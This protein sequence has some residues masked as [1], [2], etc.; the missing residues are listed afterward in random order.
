MSSKNFTLSFYISIADIEIS[1]RYDYVQASVSCKSTGSTNT[2]TFSDATESTTAWVD[3]ADKELTYLNR[4]TINLDANRVLTGFKLD[5]DKS[6]M[7][8][9]YWTAVL[10]VDGVTVALENLLTTT[11]NWAQ[12]NKKETCYLA[13]AHDVKIPNGRVMTGFHVASNASKQV[14]Y[15]S[16]SKTFP[17]NKLIVQDDGNVVLYDWK[18]SPLWQSDTISLAASLSQSTPDSL[19]MGISMAQEQYIQSLSGVYFARVQA[20]GNFAIFSSSTFAASSIVGESKSKDKGVAPYR[21]NLQ[22]DGNLVIIDSKNATTWSSGTSGLGTFPHRLVMQNDGNMVIYDALNQATWA[23]NT[24]CFTLDFLKEGLNLKQGSYIASPNRNFYLVMQVDGNLVMYS[25]SSFSSDRVVWQTNTNG[26]GTAPYRAALQKDGNLVVYDSLNKALW[27]A[28]AEGRGSGS[29]YRLQVQDTGCLS[30]FDGKGSSTWSSYTSATVRAISD[31]LANLDKLVQ[32][33]YLQSMNGTFYLRMQSDGNLVVYCNN[34]WATNHIVW[35]SNTKARGVAPYRSVMQSDGNL[36]VYDSANTPIWASGS[37]GKG[38]APYRLSMQ[39]DGNL[40]IYDASQ[41]AT[42][43]T[44]TDCYVL[45]SIN[46]DVS[47]THGNYMCSPNGLYYL[48]MRKEGNLAL[49]KSG[50][51]NNDNITW[52]TSTGGKGTGPYRMTMQ[53]DGNLVVY[54]SASTPL[55][56]SNTTGKGTAPYKLSVKD[57]GNVVIND[58]KGKSIWTTCTTSTSTRTTDALYNLAVMNQGQYVQSLNNSFFLRLNSDGNLVLYTSND[59]SRSSA[60]WMSNSANKGV[61]PY[62]LTMQSDGNLVVYDATNAAMWASGS[63]F[64]GSAPYR[65]VSQNDGNV[66]IY[67]SS[68]QATWATNTYGYSLTNLSSQWN[69]SLPQEKCLISA[70]RIFYAIL[71]SN[72]NLEVYR[73]SATAALWTSN[74]INKGTGPYRLQM[75]SDGNLVTYDSKDRAIWASNTWNKGVG[76]FKLFMQ[77]DGNLV[78]YDST[79][80]PTWASG[81]YYPDQ[82]YFDLKSASIPDVRYIPVT[83]SFWNP[84][85]QTGGVW[86]DSSKDSSA[87]L[88][89]SWQF[90]IPAEGYYYVMGA[91][92][93]T[94]GVYID[95]KQV[96]TMNKW[97]SIFYAGVKLTYGTHT[98]RVQANPSSDASRGNGVAVILNSG[99]DMGEQIRAQTALNDA[100]AAEEEAKADY[101]AKAAE[102]AKAES[103]WQDAPANETRMEIQISTSGRVGS[104]TT[105]ASYEASTSAYAGMSG[106]ITS[107]SIGGEIGVGVEASVTGTVAAEGSSGNDKAGGSGKATATGTVTAGVSATASGAASYTSDSATAKGSVSV[108]LKT[109]A[110]A[111]GDAYGGA[112]IMGLRILE[113]GVSGEVSAKAEVYATAE[114]D[115]YVGKDGFSVSGGLKTGCAVEVGASGTG[116]VATPL[117]TIKVGAGAAASFGPQIGVDGKAACTLQDGK[118]KFELEGDLALLVGINFDINFELDLSETLNTINAMLNSGVNF[119]QVVC[120]AA[121]GVRKAID[122]WNSVN[123]GWRKMIN[124]LRS[125]VE[126]CKKAFED[127]ARTVQQWANTVKDAVARGVTAAE[128]YIKNIGCQIANGLANLGSKV[129]N[130]A[131]SA[132][133]KI[134]ETADKAIGAIR[135]V[136]STSV[137][138]VASGFNQA[139]NVIRGWF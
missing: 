33:N 46:N 62:R 81:S 112:T 118:F 35:Q 109:T 52:Q 131:T 18:A 120:F 11:T 49:Y 32:D 113:A 75:Q 125:A 16:Y 110:D 74:T 123:E 7:R 5:R 84:L 78:V 132:G 127:A 68:N 26:K 76:P 50:D 36:V 12:G 95:G 98:I 20:D 88:D 66:V 137:N 130:I 97:Q 70:N 47:I 23:T 83:R 14:C 1:I 135:D 94:G 91:C 58:G 53:T 4:L 85:L 121:Q 38:S 114:G 80:L 72:G 6:K 22:K 115:V 104:D 56:A 106:Y 15:E 96:L 67:D 105:Y 30:I 40:V 2:V 31:G 79:G 87:T 13:D 73:T 77:D 48:A 43:A 34:D 45:D 133:A 44:Y 122:V 28:A 90:T 128:Q 119:D 64:R 100:Q 71:Q 3:G 107:N 92:T 69:P 42:W 21:M 25:S 124:G 111:T 55:W 126:T 19:A 29:G 63:C 17:S 54:D 60:I 61:A 8:Y 82:I 27:G 89:N 139:F 93:D 103:E 57:D 41:N 99:G 39:N 101:E 136:A 116:S 117:G 86:K 134:Q 9:K 10:K 102:L 108:S 65:L 59:W 37:Y 51:F 138:Q 24:D 129:V